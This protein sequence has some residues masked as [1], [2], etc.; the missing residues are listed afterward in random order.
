MTT[1]LSKPVKRL[2]NEARYENGKR[3]LI[4]VT[5]YPAGF[6]GFRLQ[7]TRREET[8]PIEAAWERAV[9]MR[10]AAEATERM[11]K[12]AAKAGVPFAVYC[13]RKRSR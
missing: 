2:S 8:M 1:Q 10:V 11:K 4:V 3:R 13:R 5:L 9:K 6:I 7:G 12:K